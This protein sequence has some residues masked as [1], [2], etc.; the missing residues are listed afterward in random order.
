MTTLTK[1]NIESHLKSILSE[2]IMIL[3]GA[4]GTMIQQHHLT[5]KDYRGNQFSKFSAPDGE[6]ELFLKGNNEFRIKSIFS[7]IDI[8]LKTKKVIDEA[9]FTN[10]INGVF[11]RINGSGNYK[12]K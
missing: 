9:E 2:R 8:K 11:R 1:K 3:D 5:E 12:C 6:R 4:M 7:E 10:I